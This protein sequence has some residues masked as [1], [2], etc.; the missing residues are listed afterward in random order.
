KKIKCDAEAGDGKEG[1]ETVKVIILRKVKIT[2]PSEEDKKMLSGK[3][4]GIADNKLALDQM[5]FYP[6]PGNGR[7]N[8]TFYLPQKGDTEVSIF[9]IEGK[10]VYSESLPA[11]SGKYD[12]EIDISSSPKGVYFVKV[13]QD[14]HARMKKIVLE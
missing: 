13:R 6:N 10:N 12:K 11:F 4:S 7:F 8:L 1:K 9:D 3:P 5:S 14:E 2:D